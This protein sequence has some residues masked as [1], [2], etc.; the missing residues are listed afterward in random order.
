MAG[1]PEFV[2]GSPE[3]V[4][5]LPEFVADK[6][7]NVLISLENS[8]LNT[9]NTIRTLKNTTADVDNSTFKQCFS[10]L[11]NLGLSVV[12]SPPG[13][14]K[15]LAKVYQEWV[16]LPSIPQFQTSFSFKL[17]FSDKLIFSSCRWA[18]PSGS[19]L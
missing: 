1:L 14:F 15:A 2:A 12:A 13:F 6:G 18:C 5:G 7:V 16:G 8:P 3:F 11:L 19:F 17:I 4:A 9:K 10:V